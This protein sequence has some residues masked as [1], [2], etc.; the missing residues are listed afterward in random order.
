MVSVLS[1]WKAVNVI[2]IKNEN[3][4]ALFMFMVCLNMLRQTFPPSLHQSPNL[5]NRAERSL[6]PIPKYV[7]SMQKYALLILKIVCVRVQ[8]NRLCLGSIFGG[9][10]ISSSLTF[11]TFKA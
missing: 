3:A 4:T 2:A 8:N 5:P 10:E 6:R 7:E 11:A 9:K 1:E